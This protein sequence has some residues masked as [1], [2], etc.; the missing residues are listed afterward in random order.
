MSEVV[1]LSDMCLETSVKAKPMKMVASNFFV[2]FC[3]VHLYIYSLQSFPH[4]RNESSILGSSSDSSEAY[5]L[6]SYNLHFFSETRLES[7]NVNCSLV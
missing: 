5:F 7:Y 3:Y 1:Y 2:G 4:V 6:F